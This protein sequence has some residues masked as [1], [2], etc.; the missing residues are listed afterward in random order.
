MNMEADEFWLPLSLHDKLDT[1]DQVHHFHG[2]SSGGLHDFH[3]I[4]HI[5]ALRWTYLEKF[6]VQ[7]GP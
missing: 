4:H 2:L 1:E 5:L 7:T 6:V 3:S